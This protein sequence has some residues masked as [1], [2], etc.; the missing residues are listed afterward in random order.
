ML[1]AGHK[2]LEFCRNDIIATGIFAKGL[3]LLTLAAFLP[4]AD[5]DQASRALP[6]RT[7]DKVLRHCAAQFTTKL[8]F[9]LEKLIPESTKRV[10]RAHYI[11]S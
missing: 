10:I 7:R 9:E 5:V 6:L 1:L 8:K 2:S 4:Q 3:P 11:F